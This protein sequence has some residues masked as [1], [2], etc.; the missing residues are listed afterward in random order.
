MTCQ[1]S[2]HEENGRIIWAASERLG[3]ITRTSNLWRLDMFD[4]RGLK[5]EP[6][7][8][9]GAVL[10]TP[11]SLNG[12]C[13]VSASPCLFPLVGREEVGGSKRGFRLVVW[14]VKTLLPHVP[15]LIYKL[16]AVFFYLP[17]PCRSR[18]RG[19]TMGNELHIVQLFLFYTGGCD[20][21]TSNQPQHSI[22]AY[23]FFHAC[24]WCTVGGQKE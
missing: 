5:L 2:G 14:Q 21:Y 16:F 7:D 12:C 6:D 4:T 1:Q 18:P 8:W 23:S 22:I 9:P 11:K 17:F 13:T 19:Y 24:H 20:T 10:Q 15:N 3:N